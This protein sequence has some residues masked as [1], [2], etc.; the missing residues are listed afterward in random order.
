V[1]DYFLSEAIEKY[2][3]LDFLGDALDF[4]G[5]ALDFLGDAFFDFGD[6][7]FDFGDAF[8]ILPAT[9]G[10]GMEPGLGEGSVTIYFGFRIPLTWACLIRG[11]CER[12]TRG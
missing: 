5:D 10:P 6:A 7:F 4:L 1:R 11:L 12:L 9:T 2:H 3:F 8:F